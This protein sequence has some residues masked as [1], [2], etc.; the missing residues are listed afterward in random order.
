MSAFNCSSCNA[1]N[2]SNARFCTN[3]GAS[4]MQ[5]ATI[6]TP[7]QTP[8]SQPDASLVAEFAF[9]GF[10]KRAIAYILDGIIFSLLIALLF[11]LLGSSLVSM[12]Q[13]NSLFAS[14]D[15]VKLVVGF[16]A[17]FYIAWWLYYA[18]ME[19]SSFQ[20]TFGKKILGIK[21][22]DKQG[23][24]LNFGQATGRHFSGLI[25]QITFTIGFLM[26]AFTARKQALHD[27]IAG[28]LV[29]NKRYGPN[30]IKIASDNPGSGMSVGGVIGIVFLVLLIPVTGIIAAIAIPAYQDYAI[31]AQIATAISETKQLQS[32]I[33]NH[34]SETGYW[35]NSIQQTDLDEQQM[36]SDLYHVQLI[37]D[38]TYQIMF[39]QPEII[40]GNRLE[41][42]PELTSSGEYKWKCSSQDLRNAH[43]PREC[44]SKTY[45]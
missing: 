45:N 39:K 18:L 15:S 5:A 20:G 30:Q 34:A 24:P 6:A 2:A 7:Y 14:E 38:G 28:T 12:A 36:V 16:Y 42:T 22:T 1:K 13:P 17:L 25:T 29:V 19:S 8:S 40:K 43:L 32:A 44:R 31:R 9:A 41:F 26:A 23:Q 3:C 11:F 27:M 35:P 4:L 33:T 37:S 10:W 21:V